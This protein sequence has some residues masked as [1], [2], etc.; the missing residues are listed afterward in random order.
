MAVNLA[1][2]WLDVDGESVLFEGKRTAFKNEVS[3]G[4]TV[5]V[6]MIVETPEEPGSYILELDLVRERIAWFSRRGADTHRLEIVVGA[7]EAP[8]EGQ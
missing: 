7:E 1:Y 6:E 5:E 8:P 2:H 3:P 4:E